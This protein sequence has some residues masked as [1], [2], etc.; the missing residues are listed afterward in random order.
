MLME[1]LAVVAVVHRQ[2]DQWAE[3]IVL[4]ELVV[5]ESHQVLPEAASLTPAEVVVGMN[6]LQ[7][8]LLPVPE[9]VA[10]EGMAARA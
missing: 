9:E 5:L 1:P 2:P 4:E 3:P 8:R 10:L 6:I 7:E